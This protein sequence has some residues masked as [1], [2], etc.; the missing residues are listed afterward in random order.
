M[1]VEFGCGK[2]EAT[3]RRSL[4]SHAVT[5]P[6]Q[7]RFASLQVF[8]YQFPEHC[9]GHAF[10][11]Y[12]GDKLQILEYRH[13][14]VGHGAAT[15]RDYVVG[16]SPFIEAGLW[17]PYDHTAE[18]MGGMTLLAGK[19][20]EDGMAFRAGTYEIGLITGLAAPTQLELGRHYDRAVHAASTC[21]ALAHAHSF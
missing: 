21:L 12:E 10:R 1:N 2:P 20:E 17:T 16:P 6:N 13:P 14:L 19:G 18:S 9:G 8:D 4:A 5:L 15:I 11:V 7:R 3:D